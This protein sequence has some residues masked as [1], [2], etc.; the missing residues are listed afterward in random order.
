VW[1]AS[2]HYPTRKE[3]EWAMSGGMHQGLLWSFDMVSRASSKPGTPDAA[4]SPFEGLSAGFDFF[5]DWMQAASS[6]L[7]PFLQTAAQPQAG[8]TPS[9]ML[10]T[11]DA[12]ELEK[13]IRDLQA[14]KFW[15]EQNAQMVA[16]T[17]QTLE[18]QRM[19]LE[20]LKGMKVPM[21]AIKE[22]MHP[23]SAG[24]ARA[25]VVNPMAWWDTL[26]QQFAQMTQQAVAEMKM[27]TPAA[28]PEAP[29]KPAASK[30]APAKKAPTASRKRSAR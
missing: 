22:A 26:S 23:E 29:A 27:P 30:Q 14:V 3:A 25:S 5:K 9:W 28:S 4:A 15:L 7:P 11:L 8:Q 1:S 12:Q 16:V 13:R 6:G 19:T 17:I 10:P 20:T 2:L 21:D 24:Q 18:V